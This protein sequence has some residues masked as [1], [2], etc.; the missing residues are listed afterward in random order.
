MT[1]TSTRTRIATLAAVAAIG[2]AAC[3][4]PQPDSTTTESGPTASANTSTGNTGKPSSTPASKPTATT[5]GA[6][7]K[8]GTPQLAADNFVPSAQVLD[9][10]SGETVDMQSIVPSDK[11][12]LL[13]AWAPHC[14]S[15][16]AEAGALEEFSAANKDKI[17]VVG[18]GS[19]DDESYARS[20]IEDTKVQTPRMLWDPSFDSWRVMGITA[21]PTWILV[22][23][24]GSFVDGWIGPLPEEKILESINS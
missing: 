22:N 10:I 7:S 18:V 6:D 17:T 1:L 4:S 11:P 20:F 9:V 13:W 21:T 2:L 12:V 16:R 23:G 5:A 24:D 8:A 14:P 15:C 3:S 19:Q